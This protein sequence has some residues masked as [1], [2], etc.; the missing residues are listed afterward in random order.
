MMSSETVPSG[1][2]RLEYM[3]SGDII[4]YAEGLP[5][6]LSAESVSESFYV[7]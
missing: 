4:D 3:V 7:I 1:M 6:K 2:G 5:G